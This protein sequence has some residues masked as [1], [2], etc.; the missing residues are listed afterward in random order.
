MGLNK[1]TLAVNGQFPDWIE[2]YNSGSESA[3]LADIVLRCGEEKA[4]LPE[5]ELAAGAYAVVA[6][7]EGAPLKSKKKQF[8][9]SD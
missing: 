7:G 4:R 8:Q 2:L 6:V 3:D 5:R 9:D 1:A